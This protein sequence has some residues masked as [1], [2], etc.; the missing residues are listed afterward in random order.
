MSRLPRVSKIPVMPHMLG[1]ASS[2]LAGDAAMPLAVQEFVIGA[3]ISSNHGVHAEFLRRFRAL[4]KL[5]YSFGVPDR[6]WR[7]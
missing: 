1:N 4:H 6:D 7:R 5:P 2:F 3:L